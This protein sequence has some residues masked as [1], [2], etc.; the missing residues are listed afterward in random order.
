[1]DLSYTPEEQAFRDEVRAFLKEKLPERLAAKVK[2]GKRLTKDD[3]QTWHRAI[4]TY[5]PR[6]DT[7]DPALDC[8][9]TPVSA[10]DLLANAA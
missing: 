2:G 10:A 5:G 3:D 6:L 1:M 4:D 9:L 7:G 8:E